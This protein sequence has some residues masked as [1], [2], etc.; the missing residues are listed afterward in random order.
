M[1]KFI[2]IDGF[3]YFYCV[4]YV[5]LLL[6]NVQGE[7]IGVLFG[8]VNMLCVMLKE[9]LIYMVFV[10]DVLGLNFCNDMYVDYK[11]NCLLMLDDLCVQV[12]LMFD[13]VVVLGFLIL[14]VDGVEVDDVIGILVFE[15]QC[16]GIE[17]EIFISDKDFVQFV[18]FG[19]ILVNIMIS[20]V[21]DCDGVIVKF[22]VLLEQI[23]DFLVF[24]GDSI[25]NV[26]G[27]VKCGLK[28]VVKWLVEYGLLDGL[29]VGV[30][31]V[32]GK[33]GENLC[34]VL[35]QLL[36]LCD[37]VII[38]I[39]VVL[40]LGV[41]DLVLWVKDV[42]VLCMLFICYEFKQVLKELDGSNVL[43]GV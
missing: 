16:Q 4:F 14:C 26:F 37:L 33:I 9:Q 27:V 28:M 3:F 32:G 10:S 7:F 1:V 38:K 17:V 23:I 20:M 22:G 42:D 11:V 31:K 12:Q 43:V 15:V 41:I 8:V 36:L 13:I 29:I 2:L 18:C 21:I 25:D 40:D 35:L 39:D 24:I 30:D 5:L 19:V 34:E 6:I